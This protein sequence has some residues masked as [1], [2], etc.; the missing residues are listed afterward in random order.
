MREVINGMSL[1]FGVVRA[2]LE[3]SQTAE[4][5]TDIGWINKVFK[6]YSSAIKL[7]HWTSMVI[8]YNTVASP[9]KDKGNFGPSAMLVV[10]DYESGGEFIFT[11]SPHEVLDLRNKVMLFNGKHEHMSNPCVGGT[12]RCSIVFFTHCCHGSSK[13]KDFLQQC[14]FV[15][16]PLPSGPSAPMFQSVI[17]LSAEGGGSQASGTH[18]PLDLDPVSDGVVVPEEQKWWTDADRAVAWGDVDEWEDRP[19]LTL[20]EKREYKVLEA[21]MDK[22][23]RPNGLDGD[24]C[25]EVGKDFFETMDKMRKILDRG[26]RRYQKEKL[27][28]AVAHAHAD[29]PVA[30]AD[31]D[32]D[33]PPDTEADADHLS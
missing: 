30:H 26:E 21:I 5:A 20:V 11:S 9:H 29:A 18:G 7:Q 22:I 3:A 33:T 32:A 8:N 23:V 15:F 31:A 28:H 1:T 4:Y 13:D 6:K 27:A 12:Y 14:G 2:G 25:D 17:S 19:G 24:L 16:P 10:G